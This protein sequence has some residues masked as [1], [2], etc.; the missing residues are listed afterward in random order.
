MSRSKYYNMYE[1]GYYHPI[2]DGMWSPITRGTALDIM[3]RQVSAWSPHFVN[4]YLCPLSIVGID[5]RGYRYEIKTQFQKKREEVCLIQYLSD[6]DRE[7]RY[8]I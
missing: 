5:D 2:Y 8:R 6:E 7:K 3:Q 4:G 1:I